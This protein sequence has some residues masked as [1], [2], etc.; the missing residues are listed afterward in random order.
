MMGCPIFKS[1]PIMVVSLLR[2]MAFFKSIQ[3]KKSINWMSEIKMKNIP[4]VV[5]SAM[6]F[7]VF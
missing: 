1:G 2:P 7:G 6:Y 4:M 5:F 3:K